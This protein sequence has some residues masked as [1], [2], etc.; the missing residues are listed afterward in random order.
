[1]DFPLRP[2]G[3]VLLESVDRLAH[4]AASTRLADIPQPVL[5]RAKAIVADPTASP[6]ETCPV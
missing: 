2:A 5:A 6:A 3:R 1:M 4:F